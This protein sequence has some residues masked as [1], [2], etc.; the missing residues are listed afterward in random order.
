VLRAHKFFVNMSKCA[1]AQ[2]ELEY[3]GHIISGA[4]VATDPRKTQAMI[5]CPTPTN[6][7]KLKGFL[8]PTGYYQKFVRNYGLLAKTLTNLLKKKQFSWDATT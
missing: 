1:F 3:L 4:G 5:Q 7:T 8:R 6:V 2:D